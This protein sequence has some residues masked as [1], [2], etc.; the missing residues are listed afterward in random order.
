ME[1]KNQK[2]QE[3]QMLEQNLQ[4]LLMQKQAFQMEISETI[5]A[6]KEVETS[7]DKV[8]KVIGQLMIETEKGKMQ[9]E[10]KAKEKILETRI[11]A[12]KK[13]EAPLTEQ[14]EKF[15]EELMKEMNKK[16]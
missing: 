5:A 12:I 3:M 6:L 1:D 2:I 9:E 7:K 16:E 15:R 13:Q 4:N 14:L 11:N 8:F 10:L